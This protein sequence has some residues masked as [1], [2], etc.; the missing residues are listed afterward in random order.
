LEPA[1][2]SSAAVSIQE[3][4]REVATQLNVV[5]KKHDDTKKLC[6][7]KQAELEKVHKEIAQLTL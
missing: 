7:A 5:K 3:E 2:K 6:N 1:N 4:I